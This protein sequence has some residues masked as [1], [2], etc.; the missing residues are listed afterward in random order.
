MDMKV[1][2]VNNSV[3]SYTQYIFFGF[4]LMTSLPLHLQGVPLQEA[5]L[6]DN[7]NV[8]CSVSHPAFFFW[9]QVFLWN[10]IELDLVDGKCSWFFL[11]P[12]FLETDRGS[13]VSQVGAKAFE[14]GSSSSKFLET[15]RGS[16]VSQVGAR[17]LRKVLLH[18]VS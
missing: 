14:E 18:Q 17:L 9:E 11:H 8:S 4:V 3:P 1:H 5:D 10:R 2:T 13:Q 15:D 16:Q 7:L 6:C 12:S